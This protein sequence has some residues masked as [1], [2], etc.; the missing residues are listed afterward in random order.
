MLMLRISLEPHTPST[1]VNHV[2][3]RH[4]FSV[5]NDTLRV[6]SI[7]LGMLTTTVAEPTDEKHRL[8][9]FSYFC[10]RLR[11]LRYCAR[12][13]VLLKYICILCYTF[14]S[15]VSATT[16]VLLGISET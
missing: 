16:H 13:T 10:I 5:M 15:R 11:R 6:W 4:D 9:R 8:L 1:R 14:V 12:Y 3:I 2:I 7:H